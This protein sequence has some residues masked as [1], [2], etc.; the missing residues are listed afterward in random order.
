MV[1]GELNTRVDPLAGRILECFSFQPTSDQASECLDD[2]RFTPSQGYARL[3][4][5]LLTQV[6]I[7]RILPSDQGGNNEH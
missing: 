5:A 4:K 2:S 6:S 7:G 1:H 3:N